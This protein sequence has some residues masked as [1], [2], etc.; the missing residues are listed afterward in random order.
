MVAP[1]DTADSPAVTAA[2]AAVSPP[3]TETEPVE[4]T[5]TAPEEQAAPEET[6]AEA[7][8]EPLEAEA[9]SEGPSAGDLDDLLGKL[10]EDERRNLKSVRWLIDRENES[11]RQKAEHEANIRLADTREQWVMSGKAEEDLAAATRLDEDGRPIVDK[12]KFALFLSRTADAVMSAHNYH[13]GRVIVEDLGD[14]APTPEQAR[15]LE[16]L[17]AAAAAKPLTNSAP[18][19]RRW[20]GFAVEAAVKKESARL[21][22]EAEVKVKAD[23]AARAKNA[24]ARAAETQRKQQPQPSRAG[25]AAA[26]PSF[27]SKLAVD[28]A[29]ANGDLP[30]GDYSVIRYGPQ[31]AGLPDF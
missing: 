28:T 8:T 24:Q 4:T 29:H 3:A 7:P 31:W 21:E 2:E 16:Q 25:T 13:V 30:T 5:E 20:L 1:V 15:D 9:A 23:Y 11:T 10:P 6:A 19:I 27:S 17:Q 22:R 12:E 18:L 14:F 26:A